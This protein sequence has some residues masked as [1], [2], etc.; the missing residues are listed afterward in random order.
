MSGSSELAALERR[1]NR[2]AENLGAAQALLE[3]LQIRVAD[4]DDAL[5]LRAAA[6]HAHQTASLAKPPRTKL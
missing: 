5:Q 6:N 1:V 2:L 4:I 3:S